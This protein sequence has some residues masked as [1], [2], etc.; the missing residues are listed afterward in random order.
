MNQGNDVSR[1]LL[2]GLLALQT[3]LIDQAALVAA[4]HAWTQ[5]QARPLAD[6]LVALGNLDEAHRP[7]LEG[8]AAAHLTRHGGDA[9]Q[10]LAA[11]HVG[12]STCESLVRI[13]EADIEAS[14]AHVGAASTQ[15]GDNGE[16]T[17]TY[18]VGTATSEGQRFRILRP[19]ARGGLGA[20]F[21]ALDAELHREVASSSSSTTTPTIRS[22][23]S[24]SSWRRRSPAAW[25]TRES[26]RSTA[27]GPT[28]MVGRTTPCASFEAT[29]SKRR[30]SGSMPMG[31]SRITPAS[32][33]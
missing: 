22:A 28:T 19:H 18:S 5:E 7:L 4:F 21:V 23:A 3:G 17:A 9:E 6:H 15:A 31:R 25:S 32:G 30:S 2:F 8:L 27:W 26:S 24:V 12:R 10:S 14:L 20:V 29:R 33:C 16:R 11:L 13:G 1:D